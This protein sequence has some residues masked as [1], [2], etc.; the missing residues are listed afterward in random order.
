VSTPLVTVWVGRFYG[1]VVASAR[2]E[3]DRVVALAQEDTER[4]ALAA[5][6]VELERLGYV[7]PTYGEVLA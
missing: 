4:G 6:V 7:P 3:T 5:L 1:H 2:D